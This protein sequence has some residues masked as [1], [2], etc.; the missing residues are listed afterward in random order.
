M[1]AEREHHLGPGRRHRAAARAPGHRALAGVRRMLGLHAGAGL[2]PDAPG[3]GQRAGSA[4]HLP[5][6]P[7]GA[8]VVLPEQRRRRRPVPR[9][10]GSTIVAPIPAAE[11]GDLMRAYYRRLTSPDPSRRNCGRASLVASGKAPPATCARTRTM[12]RSSATRTRAAGLRAHRVPLLRERRL[13]RSRRPAAARRRRRSA[14]FPASS[15]RA[16]TTWS[17][18]CAA[19]GTCTARGPRRN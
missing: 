19:P 8:A 18:R 12:S 9:R 13:P 7:L 11:R 16:A 3:A 5:A 6:A 4:R 14:T 1:R 17:A 10:C 2:R 15:C